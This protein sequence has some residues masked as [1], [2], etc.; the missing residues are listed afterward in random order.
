[1]PQTT[2]NHRP[3]AWM[4]RLVRAAACALLLSVAGCG[5]GTGGTGTGPT[6]SFSG[7]TGPTFSGPNPGSCVT[8]ECNNVLLRLEPAMAELQIPCVRFVANVPWEASPEGRVVIPGTIESTA[9]GVTTS[10]PGTLRL[11]FRGPVDTSTQVTLEV[12]DANGRVAYGPFVAQRR[13][14]APALAPAPAGSCT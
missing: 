12:V 8:P 13:D 7:S 9:A 10:A 2:M 1:M 11:F 3:E 5:P 6:F 14:G 4:P